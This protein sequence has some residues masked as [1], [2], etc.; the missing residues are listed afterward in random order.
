MQRQEDREPP[1]GPQVAPAQI[2]AFREWEQFSGER[3]AE[4]KTIHHPTL[5]VNAVN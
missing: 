5:V 3:F 1:S 4:L 2:A